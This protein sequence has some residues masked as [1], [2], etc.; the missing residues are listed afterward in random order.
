MTSTD[1]STPKI[2]VA[3]A[4][5]NRAETL[6]RALTCVSQLQPQAANFSIEAVVIDNGS[7]DHTQDV[8]NDIAQRCSFPIRYCYESQPGLPFARNR[9]VKE[10]TGQ[11]IA[12][13]DDDQLTDPMWLNTLFTTA[14]K[15]NVLCV[16]GSRTL[17]IETEQIALST[18]SRL[19]L[20]E[21]NHSELSDYHLHHLPCTGNVLVH[22]SLFDKWGMFDETVLDGGEDSEF[23]YR[24]ILGG[25][26]AVYNPE[27]TVQHLIPNSR[28]ARDY[29]ELI[30]FRHGR[31][32]C[33]RDVKL[34]GKCFTYFSA[35][36]RICLVGI[37]AR[38]RMMR[39]AMAARQ[40]DVIGE[41]CKWK[42]AC[43]YL[44]YAFHFSAELTST[45][46]MHR[47]R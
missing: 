7:T 26:R 3:I 45:T 6:R 43:G 36:T 46:T 39:A 23:F 34:R 42:R 2:S 15:E 10:A 40:H 30:A 17:L 35:A 14:L 21:T 32:V 27:A 4:T 41:S 5:F 20:G 9:A 37:T 47:G 38:L 28:L 25:D 11:W 24:V 16:G 22:R 8:V 31:H 18:Y 1:S 12:F 29:L 19:L 13:F 44:S 33:R